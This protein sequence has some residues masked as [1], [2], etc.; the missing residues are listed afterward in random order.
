MAPVSA[1]GI[2]CGLFYE[3]ENHLFDIHGIMKDLSKHRP[4][5]HL[6]VDFQF[7]LA[8][9]IHEAMPDCKIRLEL[10][11]RVLDP[12]SDET[13]KNHLDIYLQTER[14]AIELKY[15]TRKGKEKWDDELFVLK[16]HSANNLRRHDFL[17]DIARLERVV[18]DGEAKSGFAVLLTNDPLYFHLPGLKPPALAGLL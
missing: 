1:L 18:A 12:Q 15:I 8:W 13:D 16:N 10:P 3:R 9:Q 2:Q 17:K 5:F 14:I 7:A 6:E 11:Y 4:I